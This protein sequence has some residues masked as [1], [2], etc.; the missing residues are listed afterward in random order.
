M[1][2][3]ADPAQAPSTAEPPPFDDI[4]VTGV[5]GN[6]GRRVRPD[7]VEVL[8][9]HCFDPARL[10][11]RFEMPSPGPR[12]MELDE[13]ERRQFRIADPDVRAYA[14]DDESRGQRVWLRFERLHHRSNTEEQRCTLLV[15]GGRG[16]ERFVA[17]MSKLFRGPPTQRH[18]GARDGSP[19]IAGW[20]QWLWT[21]MPS[22]GSKSWRSVEAPKGAPPTWVVVTDTTDFYNS[23][24]YIMGDMK[25][26]KGPRAA[27][28]IL[29][30]SL[31]ARRR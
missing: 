22:H 26:R 4:V 24:D 28:T 12:W 15:I 14:M 1:I 23:Y 3:S 19:A 8:R 9:E 17:D 6:P 7:A 18:V 31:T 2:A 20:E 5:R 27:V 30:F 29:T 11:R 21:G 16:H 13:Q 10:K 25:L